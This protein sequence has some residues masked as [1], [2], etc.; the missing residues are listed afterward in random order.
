MPPKDTNSRKTLVR[1]EEINSK[2]TACTEQT[3]QSDQW[4]FLWMADE[5]TTFS[6]LIWR[7]IDHSRNIIALWPEP[8]V[9]PL[10]ANAVANP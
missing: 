7:S 2:R 9:S 8:K 6:V 1:V 5:K 4:V 3:R 10:Q